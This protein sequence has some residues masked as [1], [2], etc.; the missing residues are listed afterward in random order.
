M[1]AL[2][3]RARCYAAACPVRN[4]KLSGDKMDFLFYEVISKPLWLWLMFM[5]IV[6]TL[7]VFDLGVLHKDDHEI[8][9]AE[10]LKLA[11]KLRDAMPWRAGTIRNGAWCRRPNSFPWP[12]KPG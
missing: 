11:V 10:S 12:R 6:V 5:T 9:V 2:S 4:I 3:D 8:G 1:S 7:M